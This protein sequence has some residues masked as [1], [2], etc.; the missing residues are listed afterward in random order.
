MKKLLMALAISAAPFGIVGT[1]GAFAI[2]HVALHPEQKGPTVTPHV[3]HAIG[4]TTLVLA[5]GAWGLQAPA[6]AQRPMCKPAPSP[7]LPTSV[8]LGGAVGHSFVVVCI[9]GQV[10]PG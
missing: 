4:C 8:I 9:Y 7:T 5:P 10:Y 2:I 1:A 6:P 3:C